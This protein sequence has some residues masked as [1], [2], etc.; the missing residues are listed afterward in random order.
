[1]RFLG[2]MDI[3]T[4]VLMREV[5][6]TYLCINDK[7]VLICI[8]FFF[9]AMDIFTYVLIREVTKIYVSNNVLDFCYN[10]KII[11]HLLLACKL[12][13]LYFVD[14][15]QK[16]LVHKNTCTKNKFSMGVY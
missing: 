11:I 8:F 13:R 6:K 3:F 15:L 1:M 16:S 9:G 5:T 4:Y 10:I 2:A 14:S 7:Y 12:Q